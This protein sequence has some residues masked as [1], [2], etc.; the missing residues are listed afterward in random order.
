MRQCCT[1]LIPALGRQRP[2]DLCEFEVS[3]IYTASSRTA[4]VT[5]RPS[6]NKMNKDKSCLTSWEKWLS[7]SGEGRLA[8]KAEDPTVTPKALRHTGIR[9]QV[10]IKKLQGQEP[11]LAVSA[12]P[13]VT[14]L[15]ASLVYI[16]RPHVKTRNYPDR[17]WS[18]RL[19]KPWV[20]DLLGSGTKSNFIRWIYDSARG[21]KNKINGHSKHLDAS[22]DKEILQTEDE[23]GLR[24]RWDTQTRRPMRLEEQA[25]APSSVCQPSR[26]P[27]L[28]GWLCSQ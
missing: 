13:T 27:R 23:A 28:L 22:R 25:A 26:S 21:R 4:R 18:D 7:P 8:V 14:W 16:A 19:E 6:E 5:W 20:L 11:H 17:S 24:R 10:G 3:L 2:L 1:P 15:A 9:D 12:V